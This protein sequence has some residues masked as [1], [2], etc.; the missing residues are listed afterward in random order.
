M[1]DDNEISRVDSIE[2]HVLSD[3]SKKEPR[4][5][6]DLLKKRKNLF[7]AFVLGNTAI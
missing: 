7:P 1:A 4:L 2:E 5:T 6:F 3:V